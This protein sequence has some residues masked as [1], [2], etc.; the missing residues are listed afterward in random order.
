MDET[1]ACT[2]ARN[3]IE[4]YLAQHPPSESAVLSEA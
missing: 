1:E 3:E 2:C 4:V